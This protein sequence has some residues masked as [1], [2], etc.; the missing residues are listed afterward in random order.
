MCINFW[1][2]LSKCAQSIIDPDLGLC[3]NHGSSSIESFT[4]I[5]CSFLRSHWFSAISYLATQVHPSID[6]HLE[7]SLFPS[8]LPWYGSSRFIQSQINSLRVY[9]NEPATACL[10]IEQRSE[11]TC[12]HFLNSKCVLFL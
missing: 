10:L 4:E 3:S 1:K 8:F 2:R 12:I 9:H 7:F 6:F 11:A 5:F